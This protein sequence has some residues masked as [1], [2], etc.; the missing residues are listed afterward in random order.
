MTF[1]EKLRELRDHQGMSEARLAEVSGVTFGALHKYGLGQRRPSF[2][3]VVKIARALGVTCE[4]FSA[5][6]DMTEEE[7]PRAASAK[8]KRPTAKG[9]AVRRR[10]PKK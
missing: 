5:C 1:A 3:A 6:D 8:V 7:P 10:G 2:A 4:A 9:A